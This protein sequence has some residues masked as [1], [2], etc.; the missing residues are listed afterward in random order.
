MSQCRVIVPVFESPALVRDCLASLQASL[1]GWATVTVVDDGSSQFVAGWLDEV[2][3]AAGFRLLR[4]ANIGFAAS[5]NR[6][7]GDSEEPWLVV[8]NSDTELPAGWLERMLVAGESDDRIGM[9]NPLTNRAAQINLPMVPG[10][11]FLDMDAWLAR[12]GG[13]VVDVVTCVGFCLMLRRRALDELGLFDEGFGR[14]YCE[15]SDLAMRFL[16]AGWRNVVATNVYVYH[17][18]QGSFTD[19]PALYHRNRRVFDQRWQQA[20]QQRFRGYRQAAPL[21]PLRQ[22]L[23]PRWRREPRAVV[24]TTGRTV[25]A[26][27]Q[28]GQWARLPV[29]ALRG[30]WRLARHRVPAFSPEPFQALQANRPYSVTYVLDRLVIAGGVMSVLQLVNEL[31]RRGVDARIATTFRDP[32]TEGW[33]PL[34]TEPMVFSSAEALQRELPATDLVVATLWTTLPWVKRIRAQ[35]RARQVLAFVQD[36]EPD[37]VDQAPLRKQMLAHYRDMSACIV[38]SR[39][40]GD[41][42][43]SHGATV[44]QIGLGLD[45]LRYFPITSKDNPPTVLAMARPGTPWR[46]FPS[47]RRA[48]SLLKQRMP[49]VHILLFGC[50]HFGAELPDF[51][52]E[53]AGVVNSPAALSRL[54]SRATLFLDGSLFQGF[55]RCGLEAMACGAAC[56]LTNEGGVSE[57]AVDSE[58][59]LLVRPG[60]PEVWLEAMLKLLRDTPMREAI[61]AEGFKTVERWSH[62]DEAERTDELFRQLL[63]GEDS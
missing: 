41:K 17:Q 28:R 25:R 18:G 31:I 27:R 34:L 7:I 37:F 46:D 63:S 20:Y 51:A 33:M 13:A 59:C 48:L 5:V 30:L 9:V 43:A 8:L 50:D 44:R 16:E 36:Y 10:R 52:F 15:D 42:L 61:V 3:Q 11:S 26:L 57:Y 47:V 40:L 23:L 39:W 24:W 55:G 60:E 21:Q 19:K 22:R 45:R 29:E 38:K 49:Q 56:V 1:P 58:N 14:G 6:A 62:Q 32:L 2:C 35:G 54:Y 4:H 53:N 12:Q